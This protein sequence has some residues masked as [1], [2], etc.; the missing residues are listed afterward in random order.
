MTNMVKT[1]RVFIGYFTLTFATLSLVIWPQSLVAQTA[2]TSEIQRM[3]RDISELQKA[4][5]QNKIVPS[6]GVGEDASSPARVT[7]PS[8]S[9]PA[10]SPP[11]TQAS[12]AQNPQPNNPSLAPDIASRLQ[13]RFQNMEEDLRRLT[14]RVEEN[15][16]QSRLILHAWKN[17]RSIT[18]CV[19]RL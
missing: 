10:Q 3:Q 6:A 11:P 5:F 4:L 18:I 17:W 7:P 9:A 13:I 19:C 1:L 16:Y 12:P 8:Q 14:G 15:S 2:L